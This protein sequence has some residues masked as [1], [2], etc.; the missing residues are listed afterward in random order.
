MLIGV[1]AAMLH[2]IAMP[3]AVYIFSEAVD[4]FVAD[5][6]ANEQLL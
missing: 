3:V 5:M 4:V 6:I 2:G 1:L